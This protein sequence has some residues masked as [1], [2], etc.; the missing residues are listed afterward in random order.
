MLRLPLILPAA[1]VNLINSY[2]HAG[3]YWFPSV[4][5]FLTLPTAEIDKA[6]AK[7]KPLARAAPTGKPTAGYLELLRKTGA[8]IRHTLAGVARDEGNTA[9]KLAMAK[10][11]AERDAACVTALE[12]YGIASSNEEEAPVANCNAAAILL[13]QKRNDEAIGKTEAVVSEFRCTCA[14]GG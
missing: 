6:L 11:G 5:P 8:G 14:N 13:L 9:L 12:K 7:V 1:S 10:K 2:F 4:D 3:A